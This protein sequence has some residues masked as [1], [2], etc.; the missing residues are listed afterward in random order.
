MK[1]F[2]RR[3][4]SPLFAAAPVLGGAGLRWSTFEKA[5]DFAN[6]DVNGYYGGGTAADGTSGANLGVSF[7]NVSGLSNDA[8]FTYYSGAPSPLGTA[9][10]HDVRL[11]HDT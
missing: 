2:S 8:T 6:G 1:S 3:R 9:Y 11:V 7:V 10:A 4:H 5:W